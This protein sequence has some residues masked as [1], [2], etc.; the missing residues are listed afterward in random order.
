[1]KKVWHKGLTKERWEKYGLN[2]QMANIGA[3]VGRAINWRK[4][5]DLEYSRDAFFRALELVDLT[6]EVH[7]GDIPKL[8]ELTR[9]REVL[10]D[11]FMGDNQYGSSDELWEKYFYPFNYAARVS[12]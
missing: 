7:R 1:M 6:I 9:L 2:A 12:C 3:E 8:K 4:K 10:G 11:Y 5:G